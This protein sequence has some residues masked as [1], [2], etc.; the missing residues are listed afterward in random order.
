MPCV[1]E[2]SESGASLCFIVVGSVLDRSQ[3]SV[4][5]YVKLREEEYL[6]TRVWRF[7]TATKMS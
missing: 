6:L 5:L 4:Y 7:E 3:A 2:H 1:T